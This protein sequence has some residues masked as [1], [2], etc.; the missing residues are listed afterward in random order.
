MEQTKTSLIKAIH[1]LSNYT[2]KEIEAKYN[3]TFNKHPWQTKYY[4]N[5]NAC[6]VLQGWL[7]SIRQTK[8]KQSMN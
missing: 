6:K 2:Y 4:A 3:E 7:Y 8:W 1:S 5:K